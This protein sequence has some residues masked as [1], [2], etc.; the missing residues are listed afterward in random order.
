MK[1][2]MPLTEIHRISVSLVNTSQSMLSN[3]DLLHQPIIFY[4]SYK[5]CMSCTPFPDSLSSTIILTNT[6]NVIPSAFQ[7]SSTLQDNSWKHPLVSTISYYFNSRFLGILEMSFNKLPNRI[8]QIQIT[9]GNTLH[10]S[11]KHLIDSFTWIWN[12]TIKFVLFEFQ[13]E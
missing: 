11:L 6:G 5:H 12:P 9:S 4:Q 3:S 1:Y 7:S 13:I 10:P 8:Q 2:L